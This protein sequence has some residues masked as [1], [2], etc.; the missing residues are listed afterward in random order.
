MR[1]NTYKNINIDIDRPNTDNVNDKDVIEEEK[2]VE[3][4][5]KEGIPVRINNIAKSYG[6]VESIKKVSFALE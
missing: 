6:D 3:M 2:R 1:R 4:M 5:D